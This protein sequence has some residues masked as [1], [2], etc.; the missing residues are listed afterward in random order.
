MFCRNCGKEI[1]EGN[2]FCGACGKPINK[3]P[4]AATPGQQAPATATPIAET[5]VQQSAAA[6]SVVPQQ[7]T[8]PVVAEK[9]KKKK[10]TGLIIFLIILV[11]ALGAGAVAAAMNWDKITDV[12]A[13]D[14]ED[15]EDDEDDDEDDEDDEDSDDEDDE[16]SDDEDDGKDSGKDDDDDGKDV[17]VA[18]PTPEPTPEPVVEDTEGKV[19]NIYSYNDEFIWLMS[20]YYP[21]YERIDYYTGKI[22]DVTVNWDIKYTIDNTY[23]NNLD[24]ALLNQEQA[25]ADNKVDIFL[26]DQDLATKYVESYYTL[27][28]SSLGI[29]SNDIAN[30][31]K[32]AQDVVTDANGTLKGLSWMAYPGALVYNREIAKEVFGTDDPAV[33][34]QYVKDWETF[35]ATA[36]MMKAAGYYMVSTVYDTYRTYADN[37][38]VPWVTDGVINIDQNIM[39]W[40]Y[41]SKALVD[42]GVAGTHELWSGE[43]YNGFYPEGNVFCYF[44]P[45]WMVD[46]SM[47]GTV[48]GSV[49]YNGDWAATEGP[50]AFFWGGTWICVATGTD[51]EELIKDIMLTMTTDTELM[52]NMVV[53]ED[54]FVNN[55][56]AMEFIGLTDYQKDYLGGQNPMPVYHT[57]ALKLDKSNITA[58]DLGC[59]EEFQKAMR[60]Y[61]EGNCTLEEAL[62]YFYR[63]VMEKYPELSK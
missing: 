34:Q 29:T 11:L 53:R 15:D 48:E 35:L 54:L 38:S 56:S 17:V 30:Q 6:A 26:V 23:Q 5:A 12:F 3:V 62:D 19:L 37:V 45:T 51:N 58:Y 20:D 32:Y 47:D 2:Q 22:G 18:E 14:D 46:Y 9:P 63:G 7:S 40:V 43:W 21:S 33:V 27:P 61:F 10:K 28:I 39:K 60:L 57:N 52:K 16:D 4:V 55:K 36:D 50:Q 25:S 42:A 1:P 8:A 31:Y 41:D 49:A 24:V 59:N 13:S 44:A